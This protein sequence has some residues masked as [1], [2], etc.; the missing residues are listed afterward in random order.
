[1]NAAAMNERQTAL[2]FIA[3]AFLVHRFSSV[4]A[5]AL[6]RGCYGVAGAGV[7]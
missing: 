2:Q 1:M 3:A 7:R 6:L 5:T 4:V